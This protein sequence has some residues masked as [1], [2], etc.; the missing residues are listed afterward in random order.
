MRFLNG[1]TMLLAGGVLDPISYQL[2]DPVVKISLY[3]GKNMIITY[4][5]NFP[6]A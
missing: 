1:F 3:F 5:F 2:L 6:T 4:S